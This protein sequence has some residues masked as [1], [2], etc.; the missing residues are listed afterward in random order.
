VSQ[1]A[2]TAAWIRFSCEHQA[3][4]TLKQACIWSWAYCSLADVAHTWRRRARAQLS[5]MSCFDLDDRQRGLVHASSR[6]HLARVQRCYLQ[7]KRSVR[8]FTGTCQSRDDQLRCAT[9]PV[10][11][12]TQWSFRGQVRSLCKQQC[13]LLVIS[14]KPVGHAGPSQTEGAAHLIEV[15]I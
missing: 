3:L 8:E 4:R 15:C 1:H 9:W 14:G 7:W 13:E 10:H 11:S 6:L 2:L 5:A 12:G